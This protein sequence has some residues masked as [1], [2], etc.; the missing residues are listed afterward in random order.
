M[1]KILLIAMM[2]G[3]LALA[4]PSTARDIAREVRQA[5]QYLADGDYERAYAEY[6]RIADESANPL[7]YFSLALFHQNGWGRA[8]D[9]AAGCRLHELAA[10]GA[11]PA[12]EHFLGDCLV[13]G[14]HRDADPAEAAEWY[15][16]AADHGHGYSLCKLAE[17]LIAGRGVGKDP[18]LGLAK[19]REAAERGLTAAMLRLARFHLDEESEVY[20]TDAA[21]GWLRNAASA[22]SAEGA[23]MM[24]E[25]LRDGIGRPPN[26][27]GAL[28][29]FELAAGWGYVPAYFPAGV[30][31]FDAP[32]DP[33]TGMPTADNLAKAY[34]WL[35]AATTA[36]AAPDQR[37]A[38]DAMLKKVVAVMPQSWIAELDARVA[39]H[40]AAFAPA[41]G[42][43]Q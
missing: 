12:S 28:Q 24:A 39:E 1:S 29:F 32:L 38:A 11:I 30:L 35:T 14:V 36:T 5:Q 2:L 42:S 13:A 17:L 18:A 4:P 27:V 8:V 20:D 41:A 31:Y 16:K 33:A 10:R 21:F 15:Q 23:F 7:A 19:C 26:P 43:P 34:L 25:M 9:P 37:D 22:R 40:L 3:L 6:R